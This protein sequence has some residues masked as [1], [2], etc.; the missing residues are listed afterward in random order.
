[1]NREQHR[2]E[3]FKKGITGQP[4][5]KSGNLAIDYGHNGQNVVMM[6]TFKIDNLILSEQQVDQMVEGLMTA[7]RALIAH[8]AAAAAQGGQGNG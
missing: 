5:Q 4:L 8:K 6:L 1:M 7:K 2:R 3:Q